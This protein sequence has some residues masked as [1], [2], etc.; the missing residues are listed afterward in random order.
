MRLLLASAMLL[1]LSAL[2]F[3]EPEEV[4]AGPYNISFDLN[5]TMDYN[6]TLYPEIE[7]NDS[8]WYHLSIVFDN[9]TK[10]DVGVSAHKDWQ[11]AEWPCTYWK[12]LY[13]K[14]AK[15]AGEVRNGSESYATIDGSEGYIIR[16]EVIRPSDSKV[17]NG[18]IAEYWLDA[19]E[20]EGY[21]IMVAKS[22][23]EMISLL[24]ENLTENLLN[25]IH[26]EVNQQESTL[27]TQSYEGEPGI[28]VRDQTN[29][30]PADLV[31]IPEVVSQG[32]AYV[33][34]LDQAGNVLGYQAVSDGVN[35]NVMV[36]LNS[37]PTSQWLYATL[38]EGGATR[39]P[40]WR[41]PF[42]PDSDYTSTMFHDQRA[43]SVGA[44][45]RSW[46]E[47]ESSTQAIMDGQPNPNYS[48]QACIEQMTNQGYPLSTASIYCD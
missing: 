42:V 39:S 40:W 29:S 30:D 34:V 12:N 45:G 28:A 2:A 3:A 27:T 41:Y 36:K 1:I 48:R 20:I 31:V 37:T 6:V 17:I 25:T 38:N 47:Q 24:P 23:V 33:V 16:Q 10:A 19:E 8:S 26:V 43:A 13:L 22:E 4:S 18:T 35:R 32:P 44:A 7:D 14:A 9:E 11:Y 46:L 5:T 15:A 21:G